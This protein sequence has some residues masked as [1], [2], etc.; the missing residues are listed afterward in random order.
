MNCPHWL[1]GMV[2][3]LTNEVGP[4]SFGKVDKTLYSATLGGYAGFVLVIWLSLS[5][6]M[7]FASCSA[8]SSAVPQLEQIR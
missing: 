5:D 3:C 8:C 7:S 2:Y 4:S 6:A 1:G